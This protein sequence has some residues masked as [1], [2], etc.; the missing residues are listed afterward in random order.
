MLDPF[1]PDQ[2]APP[3]PPPG[4]PDPDLRTSL[5][6]PHSDAVVLDVDGEVDT[7]T[8]PVL[9]ASLAELLGTGGRRLVVD[10]TGVTFLASS[11]LA[12]LIRAAQRAADLELRLHL[13][14]DSRTV[15]RPLEITGVD[16]LFDLHTGLTTA[17][18]D[19]AE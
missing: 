17:L 8:A 19:M 1:P 9:E 4:L 6:R 7:L 10:L 5:S 13:V 3:F 16:Q 2:P 12:T 11:G 18:G 15:R 14:T